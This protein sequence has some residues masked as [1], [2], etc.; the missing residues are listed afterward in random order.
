M[1]NLHYAGVKVEVRGAL[2]LIRRVYYAFLKYGTHLRR[3]LYQCK[4]QRA[5]VYLKN[6]TSTIDLGSMY[7]SQKLELGLKCYKFNRVFD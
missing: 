5:L 6:A 4:S 1:K 2:L 7:T 3:D